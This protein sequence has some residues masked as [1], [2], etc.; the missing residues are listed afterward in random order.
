MLRS[1][2]LVVRL[3]DYKQIKPRTKTAWSLET[4][5]SILT[6]PIYHKYPFL[7]DSA[8]KEAYTHCQRILAE[9]KAGNAQTHLRSHCHVFSRLLYCSN[10]GKSMSARGGKRKELGRSPANYSCAGKW[11]H[12]CN[13]CYIS[14][15]N[16]GVF[17]F[18]LILN[19]YKISKHPND[20]P[21]V[22]RT[23]I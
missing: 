3:L 14:E 23:W 13:S 2:S 4:I 1:L 7:F 6:D 19:L 15:S 5:R 18:N 12:T 21:S 10:C 17:I 8:T 16:L 11:N 22:Q 9:P 20:F